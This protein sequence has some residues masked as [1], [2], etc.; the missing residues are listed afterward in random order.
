MKKVDKEAMFLRA[1]DDFADAIFRHCYFRILDNEKAKDIM[2]DTFVR[3]WKYIAGQE[4]KNTKALLYKIASNLIIDESRKKTA[5]SLEVL[6][7]K[8]FDPGFQE[9][10]K[11]DDIFDA[12][13]VAAW[14]EQLEPGYREAVTMRYIDDLTIREIADILGETENNV[15][16]RIHRGLKKLKEIT[17]ENQNG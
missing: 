17:E 11:L 10:P 16:V 7:E 3:F 1:Y 2:Q 12:K 5:V 13:S 6:A 8:G 4:V 14:V 9:R 15:S